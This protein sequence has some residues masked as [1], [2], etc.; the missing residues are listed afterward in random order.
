[1]RHFYGKRMKYPYFEGWYLKHQCKNRTIAF[2]PALHADEQGNW[3]ASIQVIT[4]EGA[5]YFPYSADSFHADEK[6]FCIAV[7]ENRFSNKGI[8][9]HLENDE[10][11]IVGEIKYGCF[12]KIKGDIM[13]PFRMVPFM[14][15]RHSV[16]SMH[17]RT[18]GTLY[19]NDKKVP[20]DGSGYIEGD[21]GYSFPERYLWT[22]CILNEQRGD[23]VMLSVADIPMW[24]FHFRGCICSVFY[25]GQEYRLATYKGCRILKYGQGKAI[26][27]QGKYL[28]RITKLL[29]GTGKR[30]K[31]VKL[32]RPFSLHAPDGGK[33]SRMIKENPSCAVRYQ[34]W[35]GKEKI[36]DVTS[37]NSSFEQVCSRKKNLENSKKVLQ[38]AH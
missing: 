34:F 35:R 7:G 10:I 29:A 26:I 18:A 1:M 13:G 24:G 30:G 3:T 28:L 31:T 12:E 15:C 25:K 36:F 20:M 8:R 32:G 2:I 16:L 37:S 9:V 21:R 23:S 38:I 22:Q 33:M 4:D 6:R 17:H 14:Q 19:I 5:W 11:S 27:K